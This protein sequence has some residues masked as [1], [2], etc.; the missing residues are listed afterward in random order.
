M[1]TTKDTLAVRLAAE[2]RKQGLSQRELA[3]R[4]DVTRAYISMLEAGSNIPSVATLQRLA[5]A[6][7]TTTAYLIE[8]EEAA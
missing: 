3:E 5:R 6:L 7:E 1:T 4:A 2:R 8:G